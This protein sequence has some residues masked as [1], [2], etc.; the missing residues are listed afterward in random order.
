[1]RVASSLTPCKGT[2]LF[3]CVSSGACAGKC[4]ECLTTRPIGHRPVE[5]AVALPVWRGSVR[6]QGVPH[7]NAGR[8]EPY[9]LRFG[10]V[11]APVKY[12][13]VVLQPWGEPRVQRTP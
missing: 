3:V 4:P 12:R 13:G 10:I 1:M 2:L 6:A 8:L 9:A 11:L 5:A 7:A